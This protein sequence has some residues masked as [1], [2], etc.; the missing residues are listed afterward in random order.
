[1]S[2]LLS[3]ELCLSTT[4]YSNIGISEILPFLYLGCQED[5]MAIK[6]MQNNHITHVI[7]VSRTGDRASFLNENDDEHFLRIPINDCLNAQL[8]PYFEKTYIFIEKVRLNN[9]R[10]LIHCLAGISRSPAVAIAYVIRH[11]HLSAD[12]A[13]QYVKQRRSQISPNFNFLGQLYEYERNLSLTSKPA[14]NITCPIVKCCTIETSFN[15]RRRFI[16]VEGSANTD[17]S[18]EPRTNILSRP[19]CLNVDL[20]NTS[21]SQRFLSSSP[22]SST[23]TNLVVESSQEPSLLTKKILR[24]NSISIK[25]STLTVKCSTSDLINTN[26]DGLTNTERLETISKTTDKSP[27]IEQTDLINTYFQESTLLSKSLQQW[28]SSQSLDTTCETTTPT[29]VLSSSPEL[30]VS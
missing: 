9:G 4:S 2:Q 12:D 16:Q 18:I 1:M 7:N 10:V 13:Y 30:L 6:T 24:P 26:C 3:H 14:S 22:S 21:Q 17:N 25:H 19:T 29:N 27:L 23:M 28:T 8:L 5:A 15:D 11:L 20:I